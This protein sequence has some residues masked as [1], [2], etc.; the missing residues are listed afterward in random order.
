MQS[1][2]ETVSGLSVSAHTVSFSAVSGWT[3]PASQTVSIAANQTVL[4]AATYSAVPPTGSLQ[5]TLTPAAA[6]WAVDNGAMQNSGI[7]VSDLSVGAHTVSFSTVNGWITPNNQ[8]V[9][10]S[11]NQTEHNLVTYVTNSPTTPVTTNNG[12][13]TFVEAKATYNGLF[14]IPPPR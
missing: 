12:T 10:I 9:S 3:T 13:P 7:T 1:S 6:Q 5:V 2:G 11:A 4:I 14:C 8:T